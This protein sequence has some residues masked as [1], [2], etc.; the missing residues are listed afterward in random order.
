MNKEQLE[1]KSESY[2]L[3]RGREEENR[4]SKQSWLERVQ[5]WWLQKWLSGAC[6]SANLP[7]L[8]FSCDILKYC[9]FEIKANI[10]K[11]L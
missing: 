2:E 1:K 7:L 10:T 11:I 8:I 4:D 5:I 9:V 3:D 6:G